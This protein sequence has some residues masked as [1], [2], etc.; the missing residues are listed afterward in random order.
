DDKAWWWYFNETPQT[1]GNAVSSDKARLLDLTSAGNG[2]FNAVMES[3]GSNC[4]AWWWYYGLDGNSSLGKAQSNGARMLAF[5][6]YPGC[7]SKC[8][9]SVM[10]GNP[11]ADITA[12]DSKGCISEAK[13]AANI[14]NTLANHAVGYSCLVGGMRPISGGLART[15]TNP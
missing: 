15:N 4:P 12:C 11:P 3:C 1:I 7:G 5:D 2:R 10:I 8:F 6:P 9:A 14:C 13:L